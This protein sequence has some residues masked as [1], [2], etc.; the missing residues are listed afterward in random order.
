MSR[1]SS[2]SSR[3]FLLN[4]FNIHKCPEGITISEFIKL[5]KATKIVPVWYILGFYFSSRV[6]FNIIQGNIK[7]KHQQISIKFYRI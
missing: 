5:S 4:L 2:T 1:V 7:F 3:I 6:K